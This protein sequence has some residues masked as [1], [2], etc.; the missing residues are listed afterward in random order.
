[1]DN[2]FTGKGTLNLWVKAEVNLY[3]RTC[4]SKASMNYCPV[5]V[6]SKSRKCLVNVL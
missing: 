5:K 3:Q 4:Y 1:M 2:I 6:L